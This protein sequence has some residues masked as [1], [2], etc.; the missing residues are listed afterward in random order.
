MELFTRM[1]WEW[2]LKFFASELK[3]IN[4]DV[5]NKFW[6]Y[7]LI[8]FE[9]ESCMTILFQLFKIAVAGVSESSSSWKQFV[10]SGFLS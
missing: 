3:G 5:L 2:N 10:Y 6:L 1:N 7:R 9:G 8:R 4:L